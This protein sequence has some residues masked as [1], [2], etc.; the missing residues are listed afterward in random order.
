M[1]G[2]VERSDAWSKKC[3]T[4]GNC[5]APLLVDSNQRS[6]AV[7]CTVRFCD[8]DDV[9]MRPDGRSP[10]RLVGVRK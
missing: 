10:P 6:F 2:R 5:A 1:Q 4:L 9:A 7:W 8:A 3:R